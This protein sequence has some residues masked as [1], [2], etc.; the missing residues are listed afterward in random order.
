MFFLSFADTILPAAL[1]GMLFTLVILA[2]FA[3]FLQLYGF[4][5][6]R[7]KKRRT[8]SDRPYVAHKAAEEPSEDEISEEELIVILTAAAMQ[9]LG[10][11]DTSRFRVVSFR[12][13]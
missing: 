1:L 13:V 5:I 9:T 8:R 3:L 7:R 12:R 2:I 4:R 11:A 6:L 10:T